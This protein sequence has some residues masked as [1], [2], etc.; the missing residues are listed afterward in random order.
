[1]RYIVYQNLI[2]RYPKSAAVGSS[3]F[4]ESNY[5]YYAEGWVDGAL[6]PAYSTP[7]SNNNVTVKDLS[8]DY[9]WAKMLW[10]KDTKK[11]DLIMESLD[12]QVKLLLEGKAKMVIDDGTVLSKSVSVAWSETKDYPPTFGAG[13]I[14]DMQ[15]SSDRL[16][17]EERAREF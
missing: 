17:D 10:F 15:V 6:S 2:D 4:V 13:N 8:L 16:H 1:M 3:A 5:I 9:A 12:A 14:I 11:S 7:F